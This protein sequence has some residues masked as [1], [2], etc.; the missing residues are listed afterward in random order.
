M[1]LDDT[2]TASFKT[3]LTVH[4]THLLQHKSKNTNS[5][6]C[7]LLAPL[8]SSVILWTVNYMQACVNLLTI[9]LGWIPS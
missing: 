1:I 4:T 9:N 6:I 5:H 2:R 3:T 8:D 7:F